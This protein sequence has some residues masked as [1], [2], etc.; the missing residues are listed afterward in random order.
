MGIS[1]HNASRRATQSDLMDLAIVAR[2]PVSKGRRT[3]NACAFGAIVHVLSSGIAKTSPVRSKLKI[4]GH[5]NGVS[6]AGDDQPRRC[7]ANP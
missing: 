7:W 4:S 1:D 6:R 5:C 3:F 2:V